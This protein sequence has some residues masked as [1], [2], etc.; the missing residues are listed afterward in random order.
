MEAPIFPQ[1]A[2]CEECGQAVT[3]RRRWCGGRCKLRAWLREHPDRKYT[4]ERVCLTCQQTFTSTGNLYCSDTCKAQAKK[5]R[6]IATRVCVECAKS[7][8]VPFTTSQH[9]TCSPACRAARM[10]KLLRGKRYRHARVGVACAEC[11]KE[12][13]TSRTAK[14]ICNTCQRKA[15]RGRGHGKPE[16]RVYDDQRAAK[17]RVT[18]SQQKTPR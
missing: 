14:R 2:S 13:T 18:G 11:A 12:F 10:G 15:N 8:P 9:K 16:K 6:Q 4:R 5:P 1:L 7:F 17:E 3:S